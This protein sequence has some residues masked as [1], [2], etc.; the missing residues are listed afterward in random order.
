MPRNAKIIIGIGSGLQFMP[1][2]G[3]IKLLRGI[4]NNIL[5]DG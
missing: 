4:L 5:D 3:A 1:T 2:S